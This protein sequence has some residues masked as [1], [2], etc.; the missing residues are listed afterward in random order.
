[1][2]DVGPGVT[3]RVLP[4]M[5]SNLAFMLVN[6]LMGLI[7]VPFY[8]DQLGVASYAIIPVATSITSYVVMVSDS[9]TSTVSRYLSIDLCTDPVAAK[10]T[11]NTAMVGFTG[12]LL[13]AIPV[14]LLVSVLAPSV[15]S[16][17]SNSVVSVQLLFVFILSAVLISVWSNNFITVMFSRNRIDL[18]N[19]VKISQVLVQLVLVVVFLTC[20]SGSVEYVGLAYLIAALVYALFGYL[21]ARRVCPELR[22]ERGKFDRKR[23]RE[24]AGISGW[25]LVNSLGNLL[26]IQTSL[27]IVN[28][29]MG[30]DAGGHFGII[31]TLIGAVS[32][33]V[34]T[35]GS[36]FAPIIYSLFSEGKIGTMNHMT[37]MAVK[38]VGLVMSMPIA[39]LC[40]FSVP[41]LQLWVGPDYISMST[42]V[43]AVLFV[44]IGIGS[45]TPA[46]PLT[47]VHLKVQV[48]GLATFLFGL[49]NVA[50]AIMVIAHTDLGLVGVGLIWS[51][52]MFAKNC[53]FNPWYIAKIAGMGHFS[54]HRALAYGFASFLLLLVVYYA[55]DLVV[56][57]PVSWIWM[58]LLGVVLLGIHMTVV[59]R[60]YLNAEE[61][62]V[63][64][65][66]LPGPMRRIVEK[67]C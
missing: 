47:M 7:L 13:A 18:M 2:N 55:I 19:V 60:L 54:I 27:L 63:V 1:M 23:F 46:Y 36:I 66:C 43:W 29:M 26:F 33:L 51:A 49:V 37:L 59:F 22:V 50:G 9:L 17:A 39:F 38:I 20:V 67:L 42:V 58:I 14:V 5:I 35:M 24:M 53:L 25:S 62:E 11:Y 6:L 21:M 40:V 16:I 56:D 32:A 15:F 34:D 61:R 45:I 41:I 4:N 10:R 28:V 8:I 52:T 65:A 64:C 12:I 48:P 3:R 57:I 30:A 44:M 31:V